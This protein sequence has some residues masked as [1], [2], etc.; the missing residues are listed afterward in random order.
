M[1]A[2]FRIAFMSCFP[3][4]VMLSSCSDEQQVKT[5]TGK[6]ASNIQQEQKVPADLKS[7]P[8]SRPGFYTVDHY[9]ITRNPD[10]DLA[11]TVR[12]AVAEHKNVLLQVGGD[13]CSWCHLMSQLIETNKRVR[14]HI[15]QHYLIMKV[16]Y[17]HRNRNEAFLSRYP[18]ISGYPHLFVLD[19][20]GKLLHSQRTD[21][22]EEGRGYNEAEF[23]AFLDRWKPR[24]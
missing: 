1:N 21:V 15:S 19:S 13:W 7:A 5:K 6:V 2:T 16:T 23:R 17:E 4:M 3:S 9:D 12:R 14:D 24:R 11:A 8:A 20:Q 10:D 18:G 22:L